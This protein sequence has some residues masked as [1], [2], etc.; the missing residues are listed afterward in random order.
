MG[1]KVLSASAISHRRKKRA[2]S[3]ITK[4]GGRITDQYASIHALAYSPVS[5]PFHVSGGE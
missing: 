4:C 1:S 2:F 3:P 5:H